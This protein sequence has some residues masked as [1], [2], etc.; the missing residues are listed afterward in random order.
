MMT[1]GQRW[2]INALSQGGGQMAVPA[3][4]PLAAKHLHR[5]RGSGPRFTAPIS[6]LLASVGEQGP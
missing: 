4:E 1:R 5:L 6:D 3:S 2:P